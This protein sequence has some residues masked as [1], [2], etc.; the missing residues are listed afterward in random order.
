MLKVLVVDDEPL[1]RARLL[2]FLERIDQV[3]LV[4]TASNGDEALAKLAQQSYDVVLLDIRMPGLSGLEVAEQIK[5]LM[6][7]SAIIFCTAYDDFALEAFKVNAQAYLLKPI[8]EDAL[9]DALA[10][11]QILNSAQIAA[12]TEQPKV[13]SILVHT[14]RNKRRLALS[15]V[16]FFRADHKYVSAFSLKGEGLVEGSLKCI[17]EDHADFFVRIHRNTLVNKAKL[18]SVSKDTQGRTW[19]EVHGWV[20]PLIV[21]RRHVSNVVKLLRETL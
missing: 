11:C 7:P 4:Q 15:E 13:P 1:A 2:R 18:A 8:K 16:L 14:N 6:Q 19:V 5:A 12:F 21:S 3:G 17:E 9:V 20:D 10:R